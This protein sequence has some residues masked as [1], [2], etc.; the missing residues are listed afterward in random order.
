MSAKVTIKDVAKAA[1]VSVATVSYVINERKDQKISEETRKK[2][3]QVVNLLNY[4]P[5][6]NARALASNKYKNIYL[7]TR[8]DD[9]LL[10][11]ANVYSFI[12]NLSDFFQNEGFHLIISGD[13]SIDNLNSFNTIITIDLTK[14]EF[15]NIGNKTFT[16]LIALS[17][18][19]NDPVFYQINRD[20]RKIKETSFEFFKDE[21]TLLTL[22]TN[23]IERKEII[24][25][26]FKN[27]IFLKDANDLPKINT[28][29]L[30]LEE[31]LHNFYFNNPNVLFV[32]FDKD[33]LF[34]TV[35]NA[36]KLA[37]KRISTDEHN[38]LL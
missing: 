23:N 31:S 19:I 27:V 30:I 1:G 36:I 15:L 12:K 5:N 10:Y 34:N 29:T 3:L 14:E 33:K 9:S 17:S 35:L 6:Q 7:I 37:D 2:V 28:N 38:I 16:P 25:N 22:D 26:S 24:E 11:S 20:Y 32:P 13:N 4:S 18:Y 21:F 8:N